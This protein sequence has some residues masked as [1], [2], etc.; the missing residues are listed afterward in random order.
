MSFNE[1]E[2]QIDTDSDVSGVKKHIHLIYKLKK[3]TIALFAIALFLLISISL[4]ILYLHNSLTSMQSKQS[5]LENKF[6]TKKVELKQKERAFSQKEL[7]YLEL[8]ERLQEIEDIIGMSSETTSTIKERSKLLKLTT[9][10]MKAW[11]L[12][13]PNG[14]P[15]LYK[16]IT[17][18]YGKRRDPMSHTKKYHRGIDLRAKSNTKVYATADGFVEFSGKSYKS[19]YGKLI[20]LDHN[21]GFKTYYAHLNKL[22]IKN[23]EFVKKGTLIALSGNTGKSSGPHLHYEI[24]FLQS[25]LNP[26]NFIRWDIENFYKIFKKERKVPWLNVADSIE[27]DINFRELADGK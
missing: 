16:G 8:T 18:S 9:L 23:R 13:I 22:Y 2:V 12:K 20:I 10:E 15:V 17:S 27:S 14:F 21:Y 24:R 26:L 6:L 19:G 4:Y 11:F 1:V 25:T 7:E 5:E 3:R